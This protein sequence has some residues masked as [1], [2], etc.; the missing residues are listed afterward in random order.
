[1]FDLT[2]LVNAMVTLMA[3]IVTMVLAPWLRSKYS[4]Q[5]L[6]NAAS[7]AS[8]LVAAAEQMYAGSGRGAEK[9]T[10]VQTQLAAKGWRLD[11]EEVRALIEAEVLSLKAQAFHSPAYEDDAPESVGEALNVG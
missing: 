8:I 4:A 10:W 5:Q 1:M 3:G 7:W 11:M 9:L 6:S 2:P